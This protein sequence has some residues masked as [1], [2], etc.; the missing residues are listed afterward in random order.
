MRKLLAI[1]MFLTSATI[2]AQGT[3]TGTVIDSDMNSPL[4]GA[5]VVVTGTQ[6]G[7]TTD[8]DGKFEIR[9]TNTTGT[10]EITYVGFEGRTIR[11]NVAEGQT[12]D[13][14]RIVLNTDADALAEV[15]ISG[16]ADLAKDRQTPVAVSTIRAA[17]I[18][19]K[20]GSQEFPEILMSTPSIYA[21]KQGGGFGDARINIRG[22]DT[23]NSAVMINGVPINDMENGA[24]YWSN[25]AG[26]SDVASAIQVQRGLGSS[27]LAVSSVGGTINVVT[28]AADRAEGGFVNVTA[29][30]D[31]YLKTVAS[32]NTGLM[33]SGFSTTVLLSQTRGDGYA[34]GT[35]FQGYNY[36][37]GFGY[38]PNETHDFQFTVTGAP[39]WHHQRSFASTIS[40]Y[41]AY[42]D[43]DEPNIKY[44]EN[45]GF[46]NGEEYSFTKNFYHKPIMSLNWDY[47]I[48]PATTLSSSFYASFGRGGGS[49]EIGTI[50]GR[51]QY[52]LPRTDDGLVRID[53]IYRW[54]SGQSVPD[55][56]E[57]RVAVD[58]QYLNQASN[59]STG[60]NGISRRASINS[61]NWFGVLSN[62]SNKLSENLTLDVGI[63]LR[64][65]KG[66]HY[67]RVNDLMGGDAFI[68]TKNVNNTPNPIYTETY[69]VEPSFWVFADIDD[70]EKIDYYND[71]LVRWAGTFGQ[72]EYVGDQ[73][74]AFVQGS[75][76]N[77]GFKR[78]EY[79]TVPT[80][81][82]ETDWKNIVGGNI[83]G[84][85][86]YNI[87]EMHNLYANAGYYSKQPLFDAVYI[88]F[89]NTLNPD[90][91]N[92]TVIGTE[93]GY[94]FRSHFLSA[95]VNLYRTSWADRFES[96]STV[97]TDGTRGVANIY[98]VTQ[99]HTG[100][101]VDANA[102][103]TDRFT[104]T[105]MFSVGNWVYQDNVTAS[106]FDENQNPILRDGVP[107]TG[108]LQLDGVK[109]G[110][111]AQ[112]TASVGARYDIFNNWSIDG[113]YR[114]A[115]NL[116][117]A[118]NATNALNVNNNPSFNFE[119]LELP[120][121]GLL[122]LGS[123]FKVNIGENTLDFR[124]NVN[125]VLD[126]TYISEAETNIMATPESVT[127]DGIDVRN[128]VYFGFGRTWTG[129]V[130]Y[131]F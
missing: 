31:A 12:Q 80:A 106:F 125:N 37:L 118:Y 55:F 88:N 87:N 54:N 57:D 105:G 7:T 32:Y 131:R 90:L 16:V 101:E 128:R 108:T 79:F 4:P 9:V 121:F 27:K 19:E 129:G 28:R 10:L 86:N 112:L 59:N 111:A 69:P 13:L 8:F 103:L 17:E 29:G 93:I 30:N 109:V 85:L 43:N 49:G 62:L 53:D 35:K 63:D 2:F 114:Y 99:V 70:E 94:G 6:T 51:R 64:S 45:W 110:D 67:R 84:G 42:S 52:A 33:E 5:S 89:G 120:S 124:V 68:Q 3:I 77:Q 22:F 130:T 1:A 34:D 14:G 113:N 81:Q 127:Y 123:T 41:I 25:W 73:I 26:L 97:G 24:V 36:Y 96:A 40:N 91:K 20:L 44:N 76:S 60:T 39:Q 72:L 107:V 98:G 47:K 21:T 119:A 78:V 48:T 23:N 66:I 15:V 65:Y 102:K 71:G 117:A 104:L 56:G 92:E 100:L 115:D 116:Y 82:S 18:Q 95:N 74:S 11:F 75:I 126:T 38:R 50:N 83:K 61:H 46:R 122:D 58:G